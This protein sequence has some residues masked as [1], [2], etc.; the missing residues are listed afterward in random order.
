MSK[1]EMLLLALRG[2]QP[3]QIVWAPRFDW[4]H[5]YA[6]QWGTL[7]AHL[8]GL[9]YY[10]IIRQL[11]ATLWH[12]VYMMEGERPGVGRQ[13]Y[14]QSDSIYTVYETAVGKAWTRHQIAS[15]STRARF[16]KEHLIKSP[17]DLP[18]ARYLIEA[19]QYSFTEEDYLSRQAAMGDDGQVVII[20]PRAPFQQFV[21]VDAGVQNAFALLHDHPREVEALLELMAEKH[22]EAYRQIARLS[23]PVVEAGDNMDG[24]ITSPELY[25]RY[26]IPFCQEVASILHR[27]GKLYGSHYDGRLRSLLPLLPETG[28]DYIE[29]ATPSPWGDC[30]MEEIRFAL[31]GQVAVWGGVPGPL[32]CEGTS[33][34]TVCEYVR[35]VLGSAKPWEGFVLGM[36][37][38][39]PANG[40]FALVEAISKLVQ[41]YR[42]EE[43]NVSVSHT[44]N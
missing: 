37:D 5:Q 1:R 3:P 22:L 11:G 35:R 6:L 39:M 4:W 26:I 32:L 42:L 44:G 27:A 2:G 36:A 14:Q 15:D 43:E 34:A 25:R 24:S 8:K 31:R 16:L 10:D 19:M 17:E 33:E 9:E 28:L 18:V 20:A 13:E 38:D 12:R 30:S 29:A 21:V 23:M 40:D 7:P 41:D